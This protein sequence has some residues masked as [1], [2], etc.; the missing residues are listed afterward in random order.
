[1]YASGYRAT[2]KLGMV[3]LGIPV[4]YYVVTAS[5]AYVSGPTLYDGD[6]LEE[7]TCR[8]CGGDGKD[9]APIEEQIPQFGGRCIACGGQ[10]AVE[11]I[12]P[13]P[14][15]PTRLWG[16]VI[17]ATEENEAVRELNPALIKKTPGQALLGGGGPVIPGAVPGAVIKLLPGSGDAPI[18]AKSD[19]TGRF[20]HRAVSGAYTLQVTAPGFELFEEELE[21]PPLKDP[22]WLEKAQILRPEISASEGQAAYGLVLFIAIPRPN[23]GGAL[24]QVAPAAP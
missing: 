23:E 3:L 18:E 6:E 13:G 16:L 19:A 8:E 20:T 15:R 10:G 12:V 7:R 24:L 21:I 22:I 9:S 4:L 1:M 5:I 11:V 14:H 17:D 2:I